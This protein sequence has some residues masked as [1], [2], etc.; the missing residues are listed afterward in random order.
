MAPKLGPTRVRYDR[1]EYAPIINTKEI[2]AYLRKIIYFCGKDSA[3]NQ[4]INLY[5]MRMITKEDEKKGKKGIISYTFMYDNNIYIST[6]PHSEYS[7]KIPSNIIENIDIIENKKETNTNDNDCKYDT[8]VIFH[9]HKSM[10]LYEYYDHDKLWKCN[11][12]KNINK[13]TDENEN[14]SE[15]E[16]I[17]EVC[18]TKIDNNNQYILD[19]INTFFANFNVDKPDLKKDKHIFRHQ[20]YS[21]RS[22]IGFDTTNKIFNILSP[23]FNILTDGMLNLESIIMFIDII[24]LEYKT[25]GI[26]PKPGKL[27]VDNIDKNKLEINI[28]NS[29]IEGKV[30]NF[31]DIKKKIENILDDWFNGME[32]KGFMFPVLSKLIDFKRT[33]FLCSRTVIE[34]YVDEIAELGDNGIVTWL[35]KEAIM[36]IENIDAMILRDKVEELEE[37]Y[38]FKGVLILRMKLQKVTIC[39]FS[40]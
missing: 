4:L 10:T 39:N 38:Q 19:S 11:D 28:T 14:K 31:N 24:K 23:M 32:G 17:C 7:I 1:K 36:G 26:Q 33:G 21:Y 27:F 20:K 30:L 16:L 34:E 22:V 18:N 29:T 15:N 5:D 6:K 25:L 13:I 9:L 3:N 12:C 2:K 40:Q 35:L 37:N 8:D